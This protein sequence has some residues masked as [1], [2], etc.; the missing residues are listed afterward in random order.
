MN[1]VGTSGCGKSTIIQLLERFYDVTR[2]QLVSR[3]YLNIDINDDFKLI[4][5]I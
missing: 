3:L 5:F 1:N 2:G 4:N